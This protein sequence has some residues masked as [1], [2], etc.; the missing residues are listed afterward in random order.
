LFV[1]RDSFVKPKDEFLFASVFAPSRLRGSRLRGFIR[2]SV[3]SRHSSF[4]FR[5]SPKSLAPFQTRPEPNGTERDGFWTGKGRGYSPL[6][7]ALATLN[8]FA[9]S[10]TYVSNPQ[11][12]QPS[13][14]FFCAPSTA[15]NAQRHSGAIQ[16]LSWGYFGALWGR[17]GGAFFNPHLSP[18]KS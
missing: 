13:N 11:N 5:H 10:P 2:P 16:T 7:D 1:L 12:H 4:G 14:I 15:I 9:A 17:F 6:A 8:R 18:V 3:F